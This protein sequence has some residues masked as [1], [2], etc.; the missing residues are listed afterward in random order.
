MKAKHD[1]LK[2]AVQHYLALPIP[3]SSTTE[4]VEELWR[5]VKKLRRKVKKLGRELDDA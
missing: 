3:R 5:E 4:L 2:R 1:Y